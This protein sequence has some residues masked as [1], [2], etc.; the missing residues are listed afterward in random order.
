MIVDRGDIYQ[1]LSDLFKLLKKEKLEV[2]NNVLDEIEEVISEEENTVLD[3]ENEV[4]E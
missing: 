4:V 1:T 3:S 2:E